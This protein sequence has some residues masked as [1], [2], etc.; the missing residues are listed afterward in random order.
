MNVVG[1]DLRHSLLH[2]YANSFHL[3]LGK[4]IHVGAGE[5][6]KNVYVYGSFPFTPKATKPLIECTDKH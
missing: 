1:Q 2:K 4:Q 3:M 5:V 6:L